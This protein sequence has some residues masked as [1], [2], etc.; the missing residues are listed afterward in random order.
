MLPNR[1]F[2]K[3]TPHFLCVDRQWRYGDTVGRRDLAPT[4]LHCDVGVMALGLKKCNRGDHGG[5]DKDA[6][7]GVRK[8]V[9]H[10][11]FR[12]LR[13]VAMRDEDPYLFFQGSMATQKLSASRLQA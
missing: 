6:R 2:L 11:I 3:P 13:Q 7:Q 12:R 4:L 10:N 5:Y 8:H 9:L 1:R